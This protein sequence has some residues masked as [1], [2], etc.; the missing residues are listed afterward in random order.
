VQLVSTDI[1]QI[2]TARTMCNITLV[3]KAFLA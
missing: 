1:L 2:I 3:L